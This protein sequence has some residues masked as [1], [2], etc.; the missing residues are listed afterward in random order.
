L[1]SADNYTYL[2]TP[3]IGGGF[4]NNKDRSL[5][6]YQGYAKASYD[7]SPGYSGS[8]AWHMIHGSLMSI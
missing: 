1:G 6:E 4:L 2:N 3:L 8:C 7:F 5:H